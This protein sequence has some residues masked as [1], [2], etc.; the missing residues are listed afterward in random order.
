MAQ[1]VAQTGHTLLN[2]SRLLS[3]EDLVTLGISGNPGQV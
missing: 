2:V 1:L 3:S